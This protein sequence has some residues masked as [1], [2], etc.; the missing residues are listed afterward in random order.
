MLYHRQCM[1]YDLGL[2]QA[3]KLKVETTG[4]VLFKNMEKV[5]NMGWPFACVFFCLMG[6]VFQ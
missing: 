5:T 2:V 3:I 4:R 6:E 1:L